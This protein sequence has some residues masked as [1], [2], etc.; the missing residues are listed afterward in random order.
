MQT[1]EDDSE[2]RISKELIASGSGKNRSLAMTVELMSV[3]G[4]RDE[5]KNAD[6]LSLT[7]L[8]ESFIEAVQIRLLPGDTLAYTPTK[9]HRAGA[10]SAPASLSGRQC[11]V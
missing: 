3:Q 9:I 4:D 8:A 1:A 5:P 6:Y 11:K 7:S 2:A 10:P